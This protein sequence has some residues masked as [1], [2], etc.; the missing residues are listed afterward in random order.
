MD[1]KHKGISWVGNMFQKFEAVCQ[2]VDNIINQV[3]LISFSF[4]RYVIQHFD[5]IVHVVAFLLG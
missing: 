3:I 1:L 4:L 5:N 2:E